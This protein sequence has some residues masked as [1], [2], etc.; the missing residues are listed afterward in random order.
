MKILGISSNNYHDASAAI[1]ID[2]KLIACSSEERFT[3]QKHD[4][5][6]P[7]HAINF[8]MKEAGLTPGDL[9]YVAYHEVPE[10]KLTRAL[11]A[12]FFDYPR[13]SK[14]FGTSMRE[15]I[16]GAFTLRSKVSEQ[17]GL[18]PAKI[19]FTPHHMSHAAHSF[20]TS[21]FERAAV[22]TVDGVGEWMSGGIFI[23]DRNSKD[24]PL[25]PMHVIPFPHSLGILYAAFTGYLGFR[26]N[27]S[28][29]STM[30]LAAFGEPTYV[31]HVRKILLPDEDGTYKLDLSYF[32]F[33][34]PHEL[35]L[36]EKFT[37]LFGPPR[38]FKEKFSFDSMDRATAVSSGEK[39]FADIACS[40]QRVTEEELI[41]LAKKSRA[42]VDSENLCFSGGVAM[43]CVANSKLLES[44]VYGNVHIPID[45]G[46]GGAAIGAALYA[47]A[48]LEPHHQKVP[49]TVG[50]YMCASADAGPVKSVVEGLGEKS[51]CTMKEISDE[52]ELARECARLLEAG[53]IV[54]W[55]QGRA[56]HGPRALGHR[57]LLIR[58]DDI[59]LAR[60]LS[61]S[62]KKRAAFRPYACSVAG[63]IAG[64]IFD[65]KNVDNY[66][67]MQTSAPV[68]A[69]FHQRLRST[70][71]IDGTTRPHICEA[72]ENRRFHL[73]LREF[74]NLSGL[75][76]LLNTSFNLSGFPLVNTGL[77]ALLMFSRT[78]MDVLVVNNLILTKTR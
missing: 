56:E 22:L 26:V 39:R 65:I 9:D 76:A 19:I 57:S 70:L 8:C 74:G 21:P 24:G 45:P 25:R 49:Q 64:T 7:V 59:A 52:E 63:E 27:D 6:F 4:P 53:K 54:G 78:E 47:S 62:V 2:G 3:M 38:N 72:A 28:E 11:S 13:S 43:N 66:K 55:V 69:E 40:I 67:W 42:L 51:F 18:D 23:G 68:K 50:P 61:K 41:K 31:E 15:A 5:N 35:P 36:T 30:A 60:K 73:L 29:C 48:L 14:I 44:G 1:V 33:I 37:R 16:N 32:N 17:L 12:S 71:H 10:V 20:F 46:D 34:N 58:P 77:E 75:P